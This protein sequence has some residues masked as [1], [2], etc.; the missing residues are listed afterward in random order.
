MMKPT[1]TTNKPRSS[2]AWRVAAWLAAGLLVAQ[3]ALAV[4]V[5]LNGVNIDG[6]TNQTFENC[7][8]EL[9]AKGNVLI[10]AKGYQVQVQQ[11]TPA[12]A[13]APAPVP[14]APAQLTRRYWMVTEKNFPGMT[15]YEIDIFIN[16]VWVRKVA[17]DEEQQVFEVTRY[18]RPG[19][20]VVHFTATKNMGSARKSHSPQHYFKVIFGEGNVGGDNVM[21]DNPLLEYR[22][23]AAEVQNFNDDFVITAR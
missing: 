16:S 17:D 19:R 1:L 9:D 7:K 22:R 11:P 4:S 10:T 5:Y 15:Q 18:L 3:D 6:V 8:V 21:I 14:A 20:N 12:P 13:A 23:H 2:R